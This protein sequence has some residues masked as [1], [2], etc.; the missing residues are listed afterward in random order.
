MAKRQ[1]SHSLVSCMVLTT[2]ECSSP[3]RT[4]TSTAKSGGT[5]SHTAMRMPAAQQRPAWWPVTKSN[6]AAN[7]VWARGQG[8]PGAL[9]KLLSHLRRLARHSTRGF[10]PRKAV[11]VGL[12]QAQCPGIRG[13]RATVEPS[14][15]P[16]ARNEANAI[17]V[18]LHS[19]GAGIFSAPP[20][21][22]VAEVT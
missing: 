14:H 4:A 21:G 18:A 16:P 5:F 13:D 20:K 11:T 2:A 17:N 6:A 7:L 12:A 10:F 9:T 22:F 15:Q 3:I 19:V 1:M 8:V